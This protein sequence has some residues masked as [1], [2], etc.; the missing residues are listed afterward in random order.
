MG[1]AYIEVLCQTCR[2]RFCEL[3][4]TF[5]LLFVLCSTFDMFAVVLALHFVHVAICSKI[6]IDNGHVPGSIRWN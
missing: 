1:E 6:A 2:N 4:G 5:A 3:M